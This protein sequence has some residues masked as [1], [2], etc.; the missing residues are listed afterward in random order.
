MKEMAT[1][2]MSLALRNVFNNKKFKSSSSKT[3]VRSSNLTTLVDNNSNSTV[4]EVREIIAGN[5]RISSH[6]AEKATIALRY[7]TIN[8]VLS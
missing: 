7:T 2:Y 4:K 5:S 1:W 3:A 8:A 6:T